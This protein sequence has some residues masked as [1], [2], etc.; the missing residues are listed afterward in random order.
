MFT[1]DVSTNKF[2]SHLRYATNRIIGLHLCRM[3][4]RCSLLSITMAMIVGVA[5]G[6]ETQPRTYV[7]VLR[8]LTDLDRLTSLQT[9]CHGGLF[10]S[11]DRNS[12][13]RWGANGDAGHYLRIDPNGE[14]VMMELDGPGVIY[15]IWSANPMGKLRIYLDGAE[16]PSYEWNFPDLFDGRL[17][18]F[19]KPLVYRRDQPQSASD[20][21]LPIPFAKH[22]KIC[23]DQAHVQY[24]HFNY[25]VYPQDQPVASFHLPLNADE[26]TALTAAADVWSHPGRDPKPQLPGQQTISKSITLAPGETAQLCDL[27]TAGEIRAIRASLQSN[28][29]YAWR[30]V[31]LRGQWDGAPGRRF[32]RRWGRFSDSTGKQ[33]S[34]VPYR[35]DACKGRPISTTRC[36]SA[37]QPNCR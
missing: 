24:Y 3:L 29:R 14:A 5:I 21:Y 26:Q 10:S 1:D 8:E 18:P 35:W 6:Q 11:W 22:I 37:N 20:C 36:R 23:A 4:V 9:G 12:K 27:Q 15:R 25:V 17:P 2:S 28:Q 16:A 30:K 32:S 33:P 34:T 7:D 31:V 19:I 13:T